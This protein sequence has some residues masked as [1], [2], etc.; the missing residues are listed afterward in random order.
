MLLHSYTSRALLSMQ[1]VSQTLWKMWS[2]AGGT[3]KRLDSES[4]S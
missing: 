3:N 2:Q 1:D 4:I